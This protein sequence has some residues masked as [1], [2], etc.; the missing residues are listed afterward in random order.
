MANLPES[1][2]FDAGVYQIETS[3]PVIG[4][5]SGVTNAPLK[6]L[7]NRT[8]FLKD[9]IDSINTNF[10]PKASPTF[11]GAPLAPTPPVFDN[12]TSIATTAFVQRALGNRAGEVY[13]SASGNIAAAD[14]GKTVVLFGGNTFALTLPSL[15]SVPVG[16]EY[17]IKSFNAANVTIQRN[18]TDTIY[19][20]PSG[21]LT[22]VVLKAHHCLRLISTNGA[23]SLAT[24]S[25]A[26]LPYSPMFASSI[27]G[28][29]YQKLPSGLIVQ[30][31]TIGTRDLVAGN[32]YYQTFPIAFPSSIL[33]IQMT[34]LHTGTFVQVYGVNTQGTTLSQFGYF[35]QTSQN[36]NAYWLAFGY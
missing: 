3:D 26:S 5:P 10:A 6:N 7:A 25:D 13:F 15:S 4:G 20:G 2:T 14:A 19:A 17:L 1:S 36:E 28:S 16:S 12:D 9:Q 32:T 8:K 11:T 27:A 24:A 34:T 23:W 35:A 30:W 33:T 31:G 21:A 22:S 18:G 29:G